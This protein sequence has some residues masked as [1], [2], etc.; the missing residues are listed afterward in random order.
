MPSVETQYLLQI[1]KMT[2][3][4]KIARSAA[5]FKWTREMIARQIESTSRPLSAERLKWEVAL[6]MYG[7]D[8]G[9]RSLIE[10]KLIDVSG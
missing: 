4:E 10:R 6:R 5:L 7:G 3:A 1:A 9:T 2:G 8:P